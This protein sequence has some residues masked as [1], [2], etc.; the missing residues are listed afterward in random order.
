MLWEKDV[1]PL[2]YFLLPTHGI[3]AQSIWTI[4]I[5]LT[6]GC[7]LFILFGIT[8]LVSSHR[9]QPPKD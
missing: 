8:T 2:P 6:A 4:F 1:L 5:Y 9:R 3:G 7:L